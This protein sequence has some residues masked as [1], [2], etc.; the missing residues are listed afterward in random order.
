M[1]I[2]D[3]YPLKHCQNLKELNIASTRIRDISPLIEC[4]NLKRLFLRGTPISLE[5][6]YHFLK[7]RADI[8]IVDL[9][10]KKIN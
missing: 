6:F 7:E 10:N 8:T 3:I 4:S 9:E 2:Q 5:S 1:D